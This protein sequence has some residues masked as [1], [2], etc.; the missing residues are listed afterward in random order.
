VLADQ[1]L[2]STDVDEGIWLVSFMTY[3]LGYISLEQR[4]LQT[5]DNPF[6]TI[7]HPCLRAGHKCVLV[8][9]VRSR[10]SPNETTSPL[11]CSQFRSC[12]NSTFEG[13][14]LLVTCIL[15]DCQRNARRL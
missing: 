12:S 14:P 8:A 2:G 7:R 3:D 13:H 5:I 10:R 11:F 6:G 15:I 4:T 1:R 9:E